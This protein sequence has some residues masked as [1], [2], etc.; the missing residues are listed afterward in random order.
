MA[1]STANARCR[2]NA[3]LPQAARSQSIP[4]RRNVCLA[5][6]MLPEQFAAVAATVAR[7]ARAANEALRQSDVN[8]VQNN[9]SLTGQ[10]VSHVHVHI[11]PRRG[12]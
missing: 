7:V 10:T 5:R 2:G 6:E 9:G 1:N 11:L 8:I 3:L 4:L 12:G